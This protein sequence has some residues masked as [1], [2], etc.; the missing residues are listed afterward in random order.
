MHFSSLVKSEHSQQNLKAAVAMMM[1]SVAAYATQ[2]IL[3]K[4]LSPEI[5]V[6]QICFFR[7]VFALIPI[8][9]FTM[10]ENQQTVFKSNQWYLHFWRSLFACLSLFCFIASFRLI[11]LAEAYTLTFACP[12]FMTALSIPLLKEKVPLWRWAT[13]IT[14]F[15][16]V[17]VMMRPGLG[18]LDTGGLFALIGGL[19]YAISLIF[20]RKLSHDHKDSNTL[21]V[22]TF[23]LL[24]ILLTL[25]FLP[26]VWQPINFETMSR[27]ALIG[28]LGGTA[29]FAMT[30]AFRLAPVSKI[31]PFDYAALIWAVAFGYIFFGDIPDIFMIAGTMLIIGSGLV[32]I[33]SE[34]K[35]IQK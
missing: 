5:H 4:L 26:F 18:V 6:M 3:V 30:Q 9:A 21:I 7:A 17:I 20:V 25:P 11:P 8:V 35:V 15:I 23:T 2:D 10:M 16:G 22:S 29:Q 27:L 13:V 32:V 24:S 34:S 12:L 1:M 19:F 33:R 14:G 31:A 28:I